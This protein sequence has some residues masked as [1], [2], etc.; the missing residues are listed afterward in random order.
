MAGQFGHLTGDALL[1][2]ISQRGQERLRDNLD[3][4]KQNGGRMNN[5]GNGN[6]GLLGALLSGLFVLLISC[7]QSQK[8]NKME[9]KPIYQEGYIQGNGVRLQY[10]DWGGSGQPLVLIPG[11]FDSPYLFEDI[12]SSLRNNFRVIA[13]SRRGHGKSEA[14]DSD[15]SNSTLVSD[16]K[17]LL[18]SLEIDKAN[19][20]GWSWAGNEITEFAI[21]YP[22]RTNKLIY[23]ESGYDLSEEA[24]K[25]ILKTLPLSPFA[26]SLDLYSFDAY[27]EWYHK[28]WFADMDWNPTL[29]ANLKATTQ[30]GSDG[31]VTTIPNDNIS[32]LLLESGM[33]YHRDYKMIQAPTLVI[34]TKRFF[35]PPVKDSNV[36][37]VYEEMEKN[38]ISPWRLSSMNQ[39]KSE[40]KNVTIKE[41]PLGT[42]TSSIFLSKDSLIKSINTFLLN[43]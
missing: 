41:M 26:D 4:E 5:K 35:V 37:S 18:D 20:L 12:G 6:T 43:Q 27:R 3:F 15:Y 31:T 23:F 25:N 1:I 8:Q 30:I 40:I 10:L 39:I 22:E 38:I 42:H 11:L 36:V 16:L 28:F 14:S 19:L 7:Q 29:E 34:Y 13:Y 2:K 9:P 24:F 17:L 21:R 33:S 32:K